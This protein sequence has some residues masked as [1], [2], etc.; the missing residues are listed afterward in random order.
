[1]EMQLIRALQDAGVDVEGSVRRF[2]GNAA[3]YEK[4][5]SRFPTDPNFAA[6]AAALEAED[7][8]GMLHA[9]HTLKGV[10]GNLGLNHIF[11]DCAQIVVSLRAGE[12]EEAGRTFREQ[13][14]GAYES[15]CQLIKQNGVSQG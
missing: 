7:W 6:G 11:D 2:A 14:T 1:M 9:V 12:R 3:L 5:L 10:S 4:F 8:E 13:L 15:I